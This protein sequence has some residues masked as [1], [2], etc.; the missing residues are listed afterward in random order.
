[1]HPHSGHNTEILHSL[2]VSLHQLRLRI[3]NIDILVRFFPHKVS[4]NL[5]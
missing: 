5:I 3:G 2:N 4:P 1:M